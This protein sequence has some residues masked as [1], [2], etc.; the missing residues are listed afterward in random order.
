M[1]GKRIGLS[2]YLHIES[3]PSLEEPLRS[4][5]EYAIE[6]ASSAFELTPGKS[7]N[8]VRLES[9]RAGVSAEASVSNKECRNTFKEVAL[10]NYPDFFDEPFPALADSW[11]YVP[12][13]SESSYR[14]YRH[15]L[16][17]PILH[18]K[19]LLLAPDHPSYEIYKELSTAA[20]LI[21]LFDNSTRIGYQR[22]WL[23]LVRESGYRISGHSLVPLTPEERDRTIESADNWCAARQRTALVRYD[24]SAP[25]RSLER[26]GFLDGN[27]RLFDYGCGRGDD[28]RGLRDNGIEAYGWDPFYAPETVRL[29]ADLVNLG[30]VINV[31][32]DFDERLEALLGAWS[33]AQRLLVVAVMLSNEND[34]RGSQFRDG[35]KTQR[36]TFQKYF[37]QREIKDYLDRALDEEAMPVAPG[38]L[39]VFR[40]KDLEQRFLLERYRSRRRHLCTLTSARPLNRTERNGLR[41]RGAELRSAERYMAYREPLDRLWAQWLSLGRTPMKEEVIDHDALLQGFGSFKGALRCIEIQRRSEIGDEAFEATLTASKNRRLADL[42][43]YFALLQFDRRQPYRNLDPSLRC[44][45]RFFFGSYRKAQDAG[46]Q[47]LSQL[48]DVDEIARACQEAAENGLGHLIWEHGQRRSLQVHS[49]LVERLPVLLRIYIGAASQIYGDWRNADLVKIHICSGKL[50]LM[51]FDDFEGKPLPRMLERVKIKLRQLDFDYFRY[52]DEYE[53]PYLYWKSRYLNEEHPN[54]PVQCAFDKTLAELDL[55]DLSGFG[56]PPAVLH[57][58]LRRHRWEIDGFQLRR[59]LT[60]PRLDD[61]CGR[62]LRFRDFIEC[63]ETW[64][65]LSAEAGFDNQPRRIESWNALNDLAEHVL[66]PI[67]EWFGMI[68]LTYAFS[69]PQLTKHI[70]ARVDAKRDQHAA[71]EQNRRGKLICERGGAAVDFIISDEDMRDVAHWVATNTPFDRLYFYDADKPIHVSYGPEHNRQV[72]WMRMGPAETRVP[73]VVAISS[74]AT[75][76]TK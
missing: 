41:N 66:D 59:S 7:F 67:I 35:V 5:W 60:Q 61:A 64:Q 26:H 17:P 58:T 57:D 30:F 25:I 29:P 2:T 54:Y 56:P 27:Y 10:L 62:F 63:G 16:N 53:P 69:S 51:S 68:H 50:S 52:G 3:V 40:D 65:K 12:E 24:F 37:T 39:Y 73:R 55:L 70:P 48:A 28:V 46:L 31:I 21:G 44:D 8:V 74:L 34:A 22:Q 13:S 43:A 23:A 15:S 4:I 36:D 49:S 45:I 6:A 72:V 33:L 9:R 18:R 1:L 75:L 47:R 11:R 32:E 20:E 42:E 76:V 71:C 38:V 14:S 19:E